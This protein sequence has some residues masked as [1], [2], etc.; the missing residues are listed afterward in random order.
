MKRITF[1]SA[2]VAFV[3]FAGAQ[4]LLTNP[5]FETWTDGEPKP[6]YVVSK[7]VTGSV[8]SNDA[9]IFNEGSKSF[10]VDAISASGT[11]NW[12]QVVKIEGGKKYKL[13]MS[14]YI[15]SGDGTDARVWCNF[16]VGD[17]FMSETEL[18][19]TNLY[20]TLRGPGA[21]NSNSTVYFA[22]IKGSW[23]TYTA[24]FTAPANA[25][26]FDFQFRTYR[27]AVVYW[28]N[29]SLTQ[30]TTSVTKIND[31]KLEA[32]VSGKNLVI[33]NAVDGSKV[34]II[35][36]LGSIVQTSFIENGKVNIAKL[37]PGIYVVRSG[38]LMSKI[39]M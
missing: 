2:F 25:T 22:D 34:E 15:L 13:S 27:T 6:W 8:V 36:A 20:P 7:T 35:S 29:C 39:K 14:Y 11:V 9:T 37:N 32:F 28:D 16:K 23:H 24:E 19:A 21:A 5:G 26:E 33:S 18:V 4:E 10:K 12:A 38:K 31:T 1:L 17:S 30:L 3:M